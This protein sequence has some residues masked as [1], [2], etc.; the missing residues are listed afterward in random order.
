MI[1][2]PNPK[3]KTFIDTKYDRCPYCNTIIGKK[4]DDYLEPIKTIV[5]KN[6]DKKSSN[7]VSKRQR[8]QEKVE[9]AVVGWL[10]IIEGSGI[11]KSFE[12]FGGI[13]D[14]GRGVDNTISIDFEDNSIEVIRHFV[15]IFD[16]T[17]QAF[18]IQ[19]GSNNSKLFLNSKEILFFENL[20]DEDTIK[21][22]NTTLKF[23]A[24]CNEKFNW[25]FEE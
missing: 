1:K 21:V 3:C 5:I 15:I 23:V 18:L 6:N 19:K 13:N 17:K 12:I 9:K 4:K 2:C 25:N 8:K 7:S 10:V 16:Y 11:G 24:F 22:G 20:K 14:I